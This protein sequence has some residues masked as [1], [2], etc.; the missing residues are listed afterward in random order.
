MLLLTHNVVCK[1]GE[2]MDRRQNA[3]VTVLLP[4]EIWGMDAHGRPFTDPA[5]VINMSAGGIVLQ[6]VRRRMRVGELL[7]VRMGSDR[8]QFRIVW[9]GGSGS[10]HAGELGMQRVTA[11][12]FLP[13]SVLAHCSQSAALC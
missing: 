12:V 5:V 7:D 11:Q 4:V 8:A 10:R 9:T 1:E 3:R 2:M 6:G 13:D